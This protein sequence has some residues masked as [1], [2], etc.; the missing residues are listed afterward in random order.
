[1]LFLCVIPVGYALTWIEPS[2][3][4]GPFSGYHRIYHIATESL[5][6]ALPEK[7]RRFVIC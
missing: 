4:C 5:K 7:I 1:M 6:D 3:H 2:W